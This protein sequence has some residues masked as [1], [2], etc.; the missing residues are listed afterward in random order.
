ML[1]RFNQWVDYHIYHP[2]DDDEVLLVK[3]IWWVCLTFAIPMT[4]VL[5]LTMLWMGYRELAMIFA[6]SSLYWLLLIIL[7]NRTKSGIEWYGLSSQ[8]FLVLF[9]F[10]LA[11]MMGGVLDSGGII[12][13]GLI[14][15]V[16]ALVFPR[17]DR[18]VYLF[19]LYLVAMFLLVLLDHNIRPVFPISQQ[20]NLI[21]FIVSFAICALFWF[22][23]LYFFAYQRTKALTDLQEEEIKST[24]L[25]LNILPDSV[26]EKLKMQP[27]V[28]ADELQNVTIL[29]ADLVNFT[30]MVSRMK[31]EDV[32][33]FLNRIFSDFD[34]F[35]EK[36]GLE[37]IKTIGDCYMAACGAPIFRPEHAQSA[38]RMALDIQEY[39]RKHDL[40][41]HIG[42]HSG[43]VVAGVI[44]LK[45]FSYDLWGDTVNLASRLE[46]EAPPGAIFISEVT[47]EILK[48]EFECRPVGSK[49]L[50]GLGVVRIFEVLN[51]PTV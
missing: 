20:D 35:T 10:A 22:A 48:D 30:E 4:L 44:G 7:F 40:Q 8:L 39:A 27:K 1:K 51:P 23:A 11:W 19:L 17:R 2:G 25:L 28:I 15:P 14:G 9:S 6:L 38:V 26:V 42:I 31:A 36:H 16:Y 34:Q 32:V 13:L 50:K 21:L 12:F 47:R 49:E 24:N 46:G 37:K 3:K 41:F 45:K 18:A 43:P 29:F 5:A 33:T